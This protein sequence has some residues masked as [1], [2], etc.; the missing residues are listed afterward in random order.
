MIDDGQC[1]PLGTVGRPPTWMFLS[2]YNSPFF[3]R[4][5]VAR[6]M[7]RHLHTYL[8]NQEFLRT[9]CLLPYGP[10]GPARPAGE[11]VLCHRFRLHT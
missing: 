2:G 6:A 5:S 11:I 10:L 4:K 3:V 7:T 1:A 9:A 8:V